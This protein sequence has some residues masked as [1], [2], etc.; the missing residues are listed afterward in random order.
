MEFFDEAPARLVAEVEIAATPDDVFAAFEDAD[1]WPRWALP[2]KRVEWTSPP[3]FGVGTTRTV[4][5]IGGVG[6]EVFIAWER[7]R[8]MAFRFTETSMPN[9]A[10]FAED[11]QVTDLGGGRTRV[12]WV[13]AMEP[14]GP[15]AAMLRV[16][17][18]AMRWGLQ[19]ML[20]R[21]RA[22][23]EGR[24]ARAAA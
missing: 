2:I 17:G 19:L 11:Y 1:S 4:T 13:M 7:G 5:M 24:R 14:T 9:T 21:F 3:P 22:H 16:L 12:R 10:A 6:K 20:N 8:R 18:F 15:S 23:V